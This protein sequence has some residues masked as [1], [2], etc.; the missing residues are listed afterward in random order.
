M[1]TMRTRRFGVAI[2]TVGLVFGAAAC[3]GDEESDAETEDTTE[4]EDTEA[5]KRSTEAEDGEM[6]EEER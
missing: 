2:A 5:R 4:T 1:K 3:G 6:T